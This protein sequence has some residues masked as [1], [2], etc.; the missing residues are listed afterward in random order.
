MKPREFWITLPNKEYVGNIFLRPDPHCVHVRE[1]VD[2]SDEEIRKEASNWEYNLRISD[3]QD[4]AFE[5]GARW[6]IA[7]MRGDAE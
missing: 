1:V 4:E 5:A 3:S 6:A 2:L 7:K